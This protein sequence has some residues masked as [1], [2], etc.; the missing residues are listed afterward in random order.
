MYKASLAVLAAAIVA[1]VIG[2]QAESN[3]ATFVAMGLVVL[4][5]ILFVASI[6]QERRSGRPG[7]PPP[8]A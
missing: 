7:G 4:G 6:V 5:V 1:L 2:W 8:A 3:P